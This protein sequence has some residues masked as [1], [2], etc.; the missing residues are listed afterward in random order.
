MDISLGW[1]AVGML[2]FLSIG[3]AG[4]GFSMAHEKE[5]EEKNNKH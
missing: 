4:V 5:K 1:I 2:I 3:A